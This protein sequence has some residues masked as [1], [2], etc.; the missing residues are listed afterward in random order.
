[1]TILP[2][3]RAYCLVWHPG[4]RLS[5]E[6][7]LPCNPFRQQWEPVGCLNPHVCFLFAPTFQCL[8]EHAA[9]ALHVALSTFALTPPVQALLSEGQLDR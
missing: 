5:H 7:L 1:M 6:L 9:V 3:P 2:G 4:K 8:L